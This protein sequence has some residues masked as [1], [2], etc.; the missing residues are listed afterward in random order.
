MAAANP[1]S[2]VLD[3]H[4]TES[5]DGGSGAD[6][7]PAVESGRGTAVEVRIADGV[8][9]RGRLERVAGTEPPRWTVQF[10]D[11]EARHDIRLG[12]TEA[13][14]RFD[15]SADES[16][17]EVRFDGEWRRGSMVGLVRGGDVWGMAFEDGEWAEDV[18]INSPDVRHVFAGR[19]AKLGE[20]R[21]RGGGA[22][23]GEGEES[24]KGVGAKGQG[25]KT[26]TDER[27]HLCETCGKVFRGSGSLAAHMLTHLGEKPHLCDTCG[28]AF[29]QAG[30]LAVHMLT[31]TDERPH[32]CETCGKACSTST[33]LAKHM[34]THSG[35][36]PYVC[37]TCGRAFSE[38]G[39]L[40]LHMRTHSG[41]KPYICETC[42]KAFSQSSNLT[43]HKWTHSGEKPN[44]EGE[45]PRKRV[46]ANG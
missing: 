15:A 39:N 34:R 18:S 8:W 46:G 7:A 43:K 31:H 4:Q 21:A 25:K 16:P 13:P 41:V 12:G 6:R 5:H 42:G 38:G 14:V 30:I 40:T 9:R 26:H 37:E 20:K 44:G 35:E 1:S 23:D 24:R 28:K 10:D 29:S 45:E 11:G 33:N 36:K 2:L 32:L 19:G 17:V 3:P 22:G 27:P